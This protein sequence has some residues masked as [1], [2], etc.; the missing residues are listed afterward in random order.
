M[1]IHS[2]NII[3]FRNLASSFF[4][5]S[6]S[7]VFH[8]SN[9]SGKT[10]ILEAIYFSSNLR[11]FRTS[12]TDN[13]INKKEKQLEVL[14]TFSEQKCLI[15]RSKGKN[16]ILL[17]DRPIYKTSTL[18]AQNPSIA[19]HHKSVEL[20]SGLPR[21]K[22]QY[23]DK[24]CFYIYPD[25]N[26]TYAKFKSALQQRNA[27]LLKQRF[28]TV[29]YDYWNDQFVFYSK[30][31]NTYREDATKKIAEAVKKIVSSFET[32][33]SIK[34][35]AFIYQKGWPNNIDLAEQIN[36]N[37]D[38]DKKYKMTNYGPHRAD[39]K[40]MI[41]SVEVVDYCSRGEQK[42]LALILLLAQ[43][44]IINKPAIFLIDDFCSE[45]DESNQE[46]ILE[47]IKKLNSQLFISTI[48]KKNLGLQET[49]T[50]NIKEGV[51]S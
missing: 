40:L 48:E 43:N 13:L 41:N 32:R 12:K 29:Q 6:K 16:T 3:G 28:D 30:K 1:P 10:S 42:K 39:L 38:N 2:L 14:A 45:L 36:R 23:L 5:F 44:I 49:A 33:Q 35:C 4:V 47:Y 27:I 20:I 50:F 15:T 26:G 21:A 34:K 11:S 51:F 37:L 19:Y 7:N 8:G 24:T 31:I 18:A 46:L 9:G 22:R 25:F 17:N